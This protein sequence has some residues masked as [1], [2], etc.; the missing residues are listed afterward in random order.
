VNGKTYPWPGTFV[1]IWQAN[2]LGVYSDEA[3]QNTSGE[4]FLRGLQ[5]TDASGNARFVTVYPGWY[6]GRTPHIHFRVRVP[7]TARTP[8]VSNFVPQLSSSDRITDLVYPTPFPYN[9]RPNRTTRNANDGIYTGAS[10]DGEVAS[11]AGDR[12]LLP[13]ARTNGVL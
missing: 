1:D 13:L 8:I 7:N 11:N 6:S 10:S 12:L 5:A 9:R 3:V 2:S 4:K